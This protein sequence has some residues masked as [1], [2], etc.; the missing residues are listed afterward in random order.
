VSLVGRYCRR[1]SPQFALPLMETVKR[2]EP[3]RQR[4]VLAWLRRRESDVPPCPGVLLNSDAVLIKAP[5]DLFTRSSAGLEV[6]V[7]TA[8]GLGSPLPIAEIRQIRLGSAADDGTVIAMLRLAIP[9]DVD[10]RST[11]DRANW[12][13][14]SQAED[15]WQA[16]ARIELVPGDLDSLPRPVGLQHVPH[17]AP[18]LPVIT[19]A[20]MSWC[21]IFWWLC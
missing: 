4:L 18:V 11:L 20:K 7:E 17:S 16:A 2:L 3:V 14:L 1:M 15:F 12:A 5:D 13:E 9:S 8:D 6:V 19:E 21:D 10:I